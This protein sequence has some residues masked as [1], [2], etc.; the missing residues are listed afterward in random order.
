[1]PDLES[2]VLSAVARFMKQLSLAIRDFFVTLELDYVWY[3]SFSMAIE[4]VDASTEWLR[5]AESRSL[6]RYF[7]NTFSPKL[8]FPTSDVI[9]VS[10]AFELQRIGIDYE[11]GKLR[12]FAY[13]FR[14]IWLEQ[15]AIN[16]DANNFLKR[17][18]GRDANTL[19]REK[20]GFVLRNTSHLANR[21]K[22]LRSFFR[23]YAE[24]Y[25][26]VKLQVLLPNDN[27]AV[28]YDERRLTTTVMVNPYTAL[29]PGFFQRGCD[30]LMMDGSARIPLDFVSVAKDIPGEIA[31][32]GSISVGDESKATNRFAWAR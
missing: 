19:L 16:N 13:H 3:R 10:T 26:P 28:E 7:V 1:M 4:N 22:V 29:E 31:F 15:F 18:T 32:F 12:A 21:E 23:S 14:T 5:V 17:R 30:Y 24:R 8:L 20:R 6:L 27:G 2:A 9:A 25:A 11:P